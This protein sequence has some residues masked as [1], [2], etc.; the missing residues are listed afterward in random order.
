MSPAALPTSKPVRARIQGLVERAQGTVPFRVISAFG[1]SQA[2]SYALALA[3]ASFMSMFPMILGALS[4][5][6]LAVRDAGTEARFQA[7]IIQIFPSSAQPELERALLG[8]KQSAGWL[9]L[10]SIGGLFWSAS[11]IFGTMEFAL[12]EIFGTKQRDMLRQKLMGVLMMLVLV[13][14]IA[15]TVA[16]N[17]LAAVLPLAWIVSFLTGTA[18]MVGLLV[19]LY[20]LVPNRTFALRDVLPGALLAGILIELLTLAFPLYARIARGFNSYGAQFA[21]FFLLATWFYLLSELI[22]LGAV[23]NRFRL[24]EPVARGLIASPLQDAHKSKRPVEAIKQE[25]DKAAEIAT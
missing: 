6:G 21:L 19:A 17:A 11:S 15:A 14:A 4:I 2:S 1:E 22:L 12:S 9:G 16:L 7:L 3:F 10:L 5:I 23:F 8:V 13:A 18:V 20:R 24:G 25:Q